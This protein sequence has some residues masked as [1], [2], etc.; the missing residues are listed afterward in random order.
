MERF[1]IG[2]FI[3]FFL[4]ILNGMMLG[5]STNV[6]PEI[7][8]ERF[9]RILD[10]DFYFIHLTDTHVMH[11]IFDWAELSTQRLQSVLLHVSSFE[12]K[13]AFFVITGDLTNWGGSPISGALN[14]LAFEHCFYK[15]DGQLYAD[16][17]YSIPVYTTPGNHE[18]IYTRS[19]INYHRFIENDTHYIITYND[20][21]LFFLNSGPSYFDGAMGLSG[22]EMEWFESHLQNCYSPIKIV[23]MH[24]PAVHHRDEHG[25][26]MDVITHHREAFV[27]TCQSHNIDLVLTGHTHNSWVFDGT[28]NFYED[29]VPINCSG[30]PTLFVQT[31]DCYES[32]HYRNISIIH[33]NVWLEPC[34]EMT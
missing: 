10:N 26:M 13:P 28:E 9:K 30:Y 2:A 1:K 23:L 31:D 3:I 11:K 20:M 18:Y 33:D 4:I 21:S 8:K 12:K 5:G 17:D 6:V 32:I 7:T 15:K 16:A 25:T 34:R 29:N 27:I 24:H 14:C 19:L 22:S